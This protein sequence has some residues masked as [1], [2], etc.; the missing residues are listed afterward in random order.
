MCKL[1]IIKSKHKEKYSVID[2]IIFNDKDLS[3]KAKGLLCYALSRPNTWRFSK[4]GIMTSCKD[5]E[6]SIET[7]LKELEEHFYLTR[8][9]G[10]DKGKFNTIYTFH[11]IPFKIKNARAEKTRRLKGRGTNII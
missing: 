2:N 4:R 9:R 10:R 1:P 8:E 5:K 3:L 7:A 11:E 6:N